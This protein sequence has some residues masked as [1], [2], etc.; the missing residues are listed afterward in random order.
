MFAAIGPGRYSA[1]RAATSPQV[2]G[3]RER[4]KVRRLDPSSWK[5][6]PYPP[7]GSR[8][9][10]AGSSRFD[11]VYVGP[12]AGVS[13]RPCPGPRRSRSSCAGRGSPILSR[14]SSSTACISYW[15][16]IGA[17][18][19]RPPGSGLRCTGK[20]SVSGSLEITTRGCVDPVLAAEPFRPLATSTTRLTSGSAG[21]I[22]RSSLAVL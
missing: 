19:G 15:V 8:R 1:T 7:A 5:T 13:A 2:V 22:S 14:P 16:T 12:V 9:N 18:S 17:S 20:C 6:R 10:V 21:Y 3:N 4:T 11:I